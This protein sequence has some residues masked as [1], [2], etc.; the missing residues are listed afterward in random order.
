MIE[1]S[2]DNNEKIVM[3]FEGAIWFSDNNRELERLVLTDQGL[4][5]VY[6]VWVDESGNDQG[7]IYKFNLADIVVN[8]GISCIRPAK[9]RRTSCLQ[10]QFRHGIEYFG[11]FEAPAAK[12]QKLMYSINKL[13]NTREM[14]IPEEG[15]FL[16]YGCGAELPNG[17][18]YCYSCGRKTVKEKSQEKPLQEEKK[19]VPPTIK[20]YY[21]AINGESAG[22]FDLATIRQM[23]ATGQLHRNTLAWTTGMKDWQPMEQIAELEAVTN[24][25]PPSIM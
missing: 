20:T 5:C 19:E 18:N 16:C 25:I 15:T 11:F 6:T 17:A 8:E 12:S 9:V 21:F 10:I 24:S 1:L 2:L 4:Y 23:A 7:E 22:P 3:E 14:Q 13:L